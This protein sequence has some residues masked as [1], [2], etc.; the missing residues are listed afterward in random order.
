[1]PDELALR[2]VVPTFKTKCEIRNCSCHGAV[3]ILVH[4]TKVV[5]RVL[6]KR[7]CK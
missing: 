7:P 6:E 5:E 2:I 4:G 1:M 3:K